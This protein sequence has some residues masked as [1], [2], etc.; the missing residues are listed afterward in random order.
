MKIYKYKNYDEYVKCQQEANQRKAKN[1]WAVEQ[2]IFTLANYIDKNLGNPDKKIS[3]LCK[4][5]NI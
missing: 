4:E 1:Q 5:H 2:N 3:G